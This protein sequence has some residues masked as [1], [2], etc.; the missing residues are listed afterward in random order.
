M[1]KLSEDYHRITEKELNK[2]Q[3]S[4][5]TKTLGKPGTEGNFLHSMKNIYNLHLTP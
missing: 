1:N 3:Y 4:L 5:M 2:I